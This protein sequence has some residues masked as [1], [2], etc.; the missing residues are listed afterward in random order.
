MT[1]MS[2]EQKVQLALDL[3]QIQN[4]AS[5]HEYY[6]KGCKHREEL[7]D[8]WSQKQ[9][10]VSWQN[11][12]DRYIGMDVLVGFY[13]DHLDKNLKISLQRMHDKDPS[14]EVKPGNLGMGYLWVHLL[15][16]PVIEV[17]EDGK[18]AKG[19]WMSLGDITGPRPGDAEIS[20]TWAQDMYAIDFIKEDGQWKIWH[21]STYVDFYAPYDVGWVNNPYNFFKDRPGGE[22]GVD[23]HPDSQ[24]PG[25]YYDAYTPKTVAQFLPR[26]PEAYRTFS[27]TF[28]Y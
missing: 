19:V 10:D 16:T 7:R 23:A 3:W 25:H 15:T 17:A 4:T 27:E 21:L 26:L 12:K 20:A 1:E 5:K 24:R 28:S 11:N 8:I 9:P 18:T 6:H 2:L 22:P 14:I 13:A